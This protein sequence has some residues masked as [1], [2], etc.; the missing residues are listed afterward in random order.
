MRDS[1]RLNNS[2][3]VIQFVNRYSRNLL[4]HCSDW[5]EGLGT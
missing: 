4:V 1:V 5:H 2:P 3:K